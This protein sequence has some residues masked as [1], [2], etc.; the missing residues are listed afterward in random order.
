MGLLRPQGWRPRS[1][2]RPRRPSKHLPTGDW[3][4]TIPF[5]WCWSGSTLL[6][7]IASRAS[8][9]FIDT[10]TRD[11]GKKRNQSTRWFI[12]RVPIFCFCSTFT[13]PPRILF[14]IPS[15]NILYPVV[16]YCYY[17]NWLSVFVLIVQSKAHQKDK[18][19]F[20]LVWILLLLLL[21]LLPC[22]DAIHQPAVIVS[23]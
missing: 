5:W 1:G 19:I 14:S 21:L 10:R 9:P 3:P 18:E 4:I 23:N 6:W 2:W 15:P 8:N 20:F 17:W 12:Q 11:S 16:Y 7:L 22:F 13:D